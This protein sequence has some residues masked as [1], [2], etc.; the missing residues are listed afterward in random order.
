MPLGM[1]MYQRAESGPTARRLLDWWRLP[2]FL[3]QQ[4][5]DCSLSAA[6]WEESLSLLAVSVFTPRRVAAREKNLLD[7]L[8]TIKPET[9]KEPGWGYPGPW[10]DLVYC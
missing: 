7:S 10:G 3:R 8:Q 6:F 9:G 2:S 5:G 1:M 4:S